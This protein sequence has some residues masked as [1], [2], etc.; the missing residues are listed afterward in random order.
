VRRLFDESL[1]KDV[2]PE[3]ANLLFEVMKETFATGESPEKIMSR[4]FGSRPKGGGKK[5]GRRNR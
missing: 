5:K 2:P 1:P 3:T 4:V